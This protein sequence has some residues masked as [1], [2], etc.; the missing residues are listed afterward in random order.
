MAIVVVSK[1]QNNPDLL[2]EQGRNCLAKGDLWGAR[3]AFRKALRLEPNVV[4][5]LDNL[6]I[7]ELKTG[8]PDLA[9]RLISK[10]RKI[11]PRNANSVKTQFEILMALGRTDMA[12]SVLSEVIEQGLK[13]PEVYMDLANAMTADADLEAAKEVY[14]ELLAMDR[15]PSGAYWGMAQLIDADSEPKWAERLWELC[16]VSSTPVKDRVRLLQ[17]R[18]V[19]NDKRGNYEAAFTDFSN[20]NRLLHK[21]GENKNSGYPILEKIL[22]HGNPNV[23]KQGSPSSRP[24][25]VIGMP[26]SGT[27]LVE[28]ILASHP[29]IHGA[30]ELDYFKLLANSQTEPSISRTDLKR[31]AEDYLQL[32]NAHHPK[33][34]RVVDKLP[35]NFEHL[36]LISACFPDAT[37]IHC[38]RDPI[39]TC[40]SLITSNMGD[41]NPYLFSF[42]TLARHYKWYERV[43]EFW[44]DSLTSDIQTVQYKMLVNNPEPEIRR[45]IALSGL[46]WE[47]KCLEFWKTDRPVMTPSRTQVTQ[48]MYK[49]GLDKWLRYKSFLEPLIDKL[50]V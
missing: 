36:W 3:D 18:A 46:D 38:D 22:Q 16:E 24:I 35:S 10:S 12:R 39:A 4:E 9:L 43:M 1:R 5:F 25:F 41:A 19:I 7:L 23:G 44:A 29:D 32:L 28:Q 14:L 47:D 26:R 21:V 48:P 33:A 20:A 27:S 37:I 49:Q 31:I 45:L 6:A 11:A 42:D 15:P 2:T 40:S 13:S 8:R 50:D 34:H 30:G 17:A